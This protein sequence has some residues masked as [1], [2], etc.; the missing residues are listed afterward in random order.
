LRSAIR[1]AVTGNPGPVHIDVPMDVFG[2]DAGDPPIYAE[3]Q[4]TQYPP[5]RPAPKQEDVEKACELL[6]KADRPVLVA[7]TGVIASQAWDELTELSES[8]GLPVATTMGGKGSIAETHSNSIG[9]VG[10]YSRKSANQIVSEADVVLAVGCTLGA[11]ATDT[12]QIPSRDAKIVH[13]DIDPTVLGT[14]YREEVSIQADAK[15]TLT[16]ILEYLASEHEKPGADANGWLE[17][18]NSKTAAWREAYT[19]AAAKSQ[20]G[21]IAPHAVFQS[22]Q[23]VLQPQDVVVADTGYMGAWT[24][25]LYEIKVPGNYF[26]RTG[27]PWNGRFLPRWG[28]R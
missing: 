11:L 8:L 6:M 7:G 15:A 24:G 25:A 16:A 19:E 26:I 1:A 23:E 5:M 22:L 12:F 21:A 14:A 18:V 13:V 2:A 9:V 20:P 28:R 4:F 17:H 3:P 10:R 27:G